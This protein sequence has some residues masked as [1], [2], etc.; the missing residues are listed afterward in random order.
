LTD[1]TLTG[2]PLGSIPSEISSLS[3]LRL[4]RLGMTNVKEIPPYVLN[5]PELQELIL[6][7]NQIQ[8]FPLEE[9][10]LKNLEA[11]NLDR[12][13]L[14]HFPFK[15]GEAP[16]S[17]GTALP[18]LARLHLSGTVLENSLK[19]RKWLGLF[20]SSNRK[21]SFFGGVVHQTKSPHQFG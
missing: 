16:Y 20:A 3:H 12:N 6:S 8:E 2:N 13:K 10:N 14:T 18:K 11:L 5:L 19:F 7:D 21:P 1:L 9:F 15:E 4:L 17:L